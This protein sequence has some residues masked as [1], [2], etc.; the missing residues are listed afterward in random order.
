MNSLRGHTGYVIFSMPQ[1]YPLGYV[2]MLIPSIN[3]FKNRL[4]KH[5]KDEDIYY[6]DYI[7]EI[8]GSHAN[9]NVNGIHH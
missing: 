6:L 7:S 1:S 4:D 9:R 3:A 8:T 2:Y 5:W